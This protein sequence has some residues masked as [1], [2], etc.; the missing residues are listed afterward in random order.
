MTGCGFSHPTTKVLQISWMGSVL[1]PSMSFH[2]P[3]IQVLLMEF[4]G[5]EE[6]AAVGLDELTS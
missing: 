6:G 3:G 4:C 2:E 1:Q 5:P